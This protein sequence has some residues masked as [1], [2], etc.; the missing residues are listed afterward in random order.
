MS[1]YKRNAFDKHSKTFKGGT[2]PICKTFGCNKQLTPMEYL[3]SEYC[4]KCNSKNNQMSKIKMQTSLFDNAKFT[5]VLFKW[6]NQVCIWEKYKTI[7]VTSEQVKNLEGDEV[8]TLNNYY[9][10]DIFLENAIYKT[11]YTYSPTKF[12]L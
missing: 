11:I 1:Y 7:D 10:Y 9:R 3:F 2:E 8:S 12:D 4:F 6:N 5:A